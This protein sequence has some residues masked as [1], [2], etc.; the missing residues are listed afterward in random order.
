MSKVVEFTLREVSTRFCRKILQPDH[1]PAFFSLFW[2]SFFDGGTAASAMD[3]EPMLFF[4]EGH[5][6]PSP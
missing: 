6:V 5:S 1:K 4:H 2:E 3:Q